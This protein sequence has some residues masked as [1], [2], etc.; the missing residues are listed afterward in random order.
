MARS[1]REGLDYFPL[2][3]NFYKNRKIR[4]LLLS[5]GPNALAVWLVIMAKIYEGKGYYL[6]Y[7]EDTCFDIGDAIAVS[8]GAV[9]EIVKACIKVKLFNKTLFDNYGILTSKG[10]QEQ[11]SE[12]MKTAKRKNVINSKFLITSEE[13]PI[14]SEEKAINS[15]E[16]PNTSEEMQQS[17]INKSKV[18]KNKLNISSG[19]H[20]ESTKYV[21]GE[22]N[23]EF[24]SEIDGDIDAEDNKKVLDCY[25]SNFMHKGTFVPSAVTEELLEMVKLSSSDLVIAAMKLTVQNGATSL[26]YTK[27]ILKRWSD[28]GV[29]TLEDA[30][31][32]ELKFKQQQ[33]TSRYGKPMRAPEPIPKFKR[34]PQVDEEIDPAEVEAVQ[35][36]LRAL[37]GGNHEE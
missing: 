15:E 31:Q 21:V 35:A 7:D 13:M 16:I 5:Q 19:S 26:A 9:N 36:R 27:K 4:R 1:I 11:Y 32:H 22:E 25:K 33:S 12:I 29:R 30:R 17:K 2:D 6:Q 8:E 20:I 34:E 10:I 23:L 28:E 37:I 3:T 18:N 24:I 14:T